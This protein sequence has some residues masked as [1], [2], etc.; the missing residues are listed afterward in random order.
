MSENNAPPLPAIPPEPADEAARRRETMLAFHLGALSDEEE[1]LI[2]GRLETSP[3]WQQAGAEAQAMLKGLNEDGA[4]QVQVPADLGERALKLL[5]EAKEKR[6]VA[7]A[8]SRQPDQR[9]A[10]R[11]FFTPR[12]AAAIFVACL[13][14]VAVTAARYYWPGGA[15]E[16]IRWQAEAEMAAGAPF[17]PF[18]Q[19]RDARTQRPIA[20]ARLAAYLTPCSG[21]PAKT[22]IGRG[23]TDDTGVLSG[24]PWV[25]PEVAAGDYRLVIEARSALGSVRDRVERTVKVSRSAKLALAPDRSQARPGETIRARTLLVSAAGDKPLADKPVKIDLFDP[26]RNRLCRVEQRS[27]RFGL[28]WAEFPLDNAAPEGTY[29]LRAESDGLTAERPIE[30]KQYKLPPFRVSLTL[31]RTWFGPSDSVS[32]KIEARTFDGHPVAGATGTLTAVDADGNAIRPALDKVLLDAGGTQQLDLGRIAP[33][34]KQ[35]VRVA[36]LTLDDPQL[37]AEV[38]L[39][40]D[41]KNTIAR[42]LSLPVRPDARGRLLIR[43]DKVILRGGDTL[44]VTVFSGE[45]LRGKAVALALRQDGKTVC[46]GGVILNGTQGAAVL[47]IPAGVT[48]VLSLEASM[49]FDQSR[50]WSD[51]RR[52]LVAGDSR[53]Q[54]VASAD[55]PKYRPGDR[56][57]LSFSVTDAKGT[58]IPAA[59]SVV[60]VDAALL[61]MTGENPGLAQALQAAGLAILR[62]PDSLLDVAALRPEECAG[63]AACAALAQLRPRDPEQAQQRLADMTVDT[64]NAKLTAQAT[65]HTQLRERLLLSLWALLAVALALVFVNSACLASSQYPESALLTTLGMVPIVTMALSAFSICAVFFAEQKEPSAFLPCV[66]TAIL[67][68]S[69]AVLLARARQLH[70]PGFGSRQILVTAISD[71]S[72]LFVALFGLVAMQNG[73]GIALFVILGLVPVGVFQFNEATARKSEEGTLLLRTGCAVA[74]ACLL[75]GI[76][77]LWATVGAKMAEPM[78]RVASGTVPEPRAVAS[79]SPAMPKGESKGTGRYLFTET[80]PEIKFNGSSSAVSK[81]GYTFASPAASPPARLRWDFPETMIFAPQIITDEHGNASYDLSV[82]DSLT[83]WRVQTDA[84]SPSGGTAWTQT[85]LVVTQ[86]FSVDLTLPT[87]ITAG[88]VLFVPA[89]VSNHT[90]SEKLV[91]VSLEISGATALEGTT[92]QLRLGPKAVAAAEFVLRFDK[93]GAARLK[94]DA[95]AVQGAA[96]E[97]DS[98]ERLLTVLPDGR[99]VSFTASALIGE[100]GELDVLVPDDAL[101]GTIRGSLRLHRGPLTQMIEG[102]DAMLHEPYGCF[103]QTSSTTYPNVMIARYLKAN[104]IA[105]PEIE[106]R[107]QRFIGQGYQRLLGFEVG[108]GSGSFSLYG[109]AP[110][111]TW[112]TAYGLMEFSDMAAA[113]PV[114]PALLE[115]TR[116]W[117]KTKMRGDGSFEVD[118]YRGHENT[119]LGL[120]STAYVVMALG[121]GAP[122]ASVRFL[123]SHIAEIERD[124]YLC[125]LT[126]N[127]LLRADRATAAQLAGKLRALAQ[128]DAQRKTAVLPGRATL[129]WGYGDAAAIEA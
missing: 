111:S 109:H 98:V 104:G 67:L 93:P 87:D 126:A 50:V 65:E 110:A 119:P 20:G 9:P 38:L 68:I 51:S 14:P 81:S 8:S 54:V 30:V 94:A 33:G 92:R 95:R 10:V 82:A 27:T 45:P 1:A 15:V 29:L 60:G 46:A 113:Y 75:L 90:T 85:D 118:T 76:G 61:A 128:I 117:L 18:L 19:V 25:V 41:E 116:A 17:A 122:D 44:K 105:K 49:P 89:V 21:S 115:R 99:P 16:S 77:F 12:V 52:L 22:D 79:P 28:A 3:E 57:K 73:A 37:P 5:R 83:R 59:V 34:E 32:V 4:A 97:Q 7:P 23:S 48:G 62:Q 127:A 64:A 69:H 71:A 86:P 11:T 100:D 78:G 124:A 84:I 35:D 108:R 40:A 58:G 24:A 80:S 39:I 107:A 121:D 36:V 125:A 47:A 91:D 120:A 114:D 63:P 103:E 26:A 129:A 53:V 2:R 13:L 88:D 101:P 102:L 56:T 72:L 42:S 70:Q 31:D 96:D 123:R 43:P 6:A 112:L 106:Q 74:P 55:H 66:L